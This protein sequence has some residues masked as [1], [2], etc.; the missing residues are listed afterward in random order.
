MV[1]NEILKDL[2]L[3]LK[4]YY[5][6]YFDI[7]GYRAFIENN[8]EE[9]KK[10][11]FEILLAVGDIEAE[12]RR[13]ESKVKINI[14]TYSDNFLLFFEQANFSEYYALKIFAQLMQ[15]VQVKLL[16]N[17]KILLRGG[18]TKGEFFVNDQIVFGEGLI[19]AV[20]LEEKDARFPRVVIDRETFSNAVEEL[21]E[22]GLLNKDNDQQVYVHYLV[23]EDS[24]KLA[25]G[26]CEVLINKYGKYHNNVK[27]LEKIL[28]VERTLVKYLWLL[29]Y[30]NYSC[31]RVQCNHLKIDYEIKL[32]ER[33][34]KME[35]SCKKKIRNL[36]TK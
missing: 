4:D 6:C 29:I 24:L 32:N 21:I 34:L 12:I 9:H 22:E 15:K 1:T 8:P 31:E 20:T 28:Q 17:F 27:D 16:M 25:K 18:I 5:I 26:K 14:K 7:L 13:K 35:I 3:P 2:N 36:S 19:K 33:L 30:F 23:N 11:L 10:F